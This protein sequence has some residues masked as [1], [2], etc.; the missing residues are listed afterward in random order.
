MSIE[1]VFRKNGNIR[2]LRTLSESIDQLQPA[3][4]SMASIEELLANQNAIQL[5]A[6]LKRYLRELPEPLLTFSLYKLFV[7]CGRIVE[8]QGQKKKVLHLA[9]C[10]LPKPNRDTVMMLF[11]CLKWVSTFSDTNKM[12]IPNLARVIAPSVLF[13]RPS[14]TSST[15][16]VVAASAAVDLRQGAQEEIN[17][18]ETLIRE[19]DDL[20]I[21]SSS[22][23]SSIYNYIDYPSTFLFIDSF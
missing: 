11:C 14:Q 7:Q 9:C 1:G 8:D 17:V 4:N 18:I 12:D 21:V 23:S 5:A 16:I 22:S 6:L 3:A 2:Q 13:D 10:L 20:S 15:S 19:V